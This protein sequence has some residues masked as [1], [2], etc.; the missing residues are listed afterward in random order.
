M[1][2]KEKNGLI[3]QRRLL[4]EKCKQK[5]KEINRLKTE[6]SRIMEIINLNL[7]NYGYQIKVDIEITGGERN[8]T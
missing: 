2:E 4:R 5:D 3:K 8:D 1:N 7:Y 6:I